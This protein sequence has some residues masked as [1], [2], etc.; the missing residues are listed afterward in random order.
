PAAPQG[1][2]ATDGSQASGVAITWSAVAGATGYRV[3][4]G[5]S[6]VSL[7]P[8]ASVS[9]LTWFD[10]SAQPGVVYT[11]AVRAITP[12]GDGPQSAADTGFAA[13]VT[14]GVTGVNAS[15]G[16]Q[17]SG[18]RIVWQPLAAA[19][20]YRI[21]RSGGDE[22]LQVGAVGASTTIFTDNSIQPG[23]L[24]TYFVRATVVGGA[25]GPPSQV[26]TGWRAMLAPLGVAASDGASLDGIEVSWS[27][28]QGAIEYRVFRSLGNAAPTPVGTTEGQLQFRDTSALSGLTYSYVVRA[29]GQVEGALSP[30]SIPNEGWR[31]LAAPTGVAASDGTT[32]GGVLV[33]WLPSSG[34]VTYRIS[35]ALETQGAVGPPT[36]IAVGVTGLQFNDST[37]AVGALYRYRVQAVAAN[38][39]RVS[40]LSVFDAGYLLLPSP[41]SVNATDGTSTVQVGVSWAGVPGA[42]GYQVLRRI[43]SAPFELLGSVNGAL[44]WADVTANPGQPYDYAIRSVAATGVSQPS[45]VDT[46]YRQLAAPTGIAASDGTRSDGVMVQWGGSN[47]AQSFE[48]WRSLGSAAP[49]RLA[50]LSASVPREYIDAGAIPGVVYSFTV[51]AVGLIGVSASSAA[52]SGFRQAV[53]PNSVLA[54][55]GTSTQHVAVSWSAV[56]SALGYKVLRSTGGS[57]PEVRATLGATVVTWN[58]SQAASGVVYEYS[59]RTVMPSGESIASGADTGYRG[60]TAPVG[61]QASDGSSSAHVA[62][63]WLSVSGAT[64]YQV[65]RSVGGGTP[66]ILGS[67]PTGQLSFTDSTAMHGQVFN[68]FVAALN[69]AGPSALSASNSGYRQVVPPLDVQATDG[70]LPSGVRISWS[71]SAGATGYRVFRATMNGSVAG[72]VTQIGVTSNALEFVDSSAAFGVVYRYSLRTVGAPNGSVSVESTGDLGSRGL[73]APINFVATDGQFTDRVALSWTASAGAESYQVFRG[74][75][76]SPLV[77]SIVGTSFNDTSAPAGTRFNYSVRAVGPTGSSAPSA[78]DDGFRQL[79]SPT[80]VQA[81]DGLSSDSVSVSWNPVAGAVAYELFRSGASTPITV[82]AATNFVDSPVNGIPAVGLAYSYTVRARGAVGISAPSVADSGYRA[83]PAPTGVVASDG[84]SAL[85]VTVSWNAVP[86]AVVYRVWRATGSAPLAVIATV[87]NPGPYVDSTASIG[88]VHRYAVS[89]VSAAGNGLTSPSDDGCRRLASPSGIAASDG[90]ST[91]HVVINWQA[92]VGAVGYQVFRDGSETPIAEV[93]SGFSVLDTQALPGVQHA[94]AVRAQGAATAMLSAMSSADVGF[95]QMRAPESVSA[96][97]GDLLAGVQVSWSSVVGATAYQVLRSP[98]TNGVLGPAVQRGVVL[99]G[100]PGGLVFL[101]ALAVPGVRYAYGVAAVGTAPGAASLPS[102]FDFGHRNRAGATNVQASENIPAHVL[103]TWTLAAAGTPAVSGYEVRRVVGEETPVV[104]TSALAATVTQYDDTTAVPGT[105]YTYEVR[106]RYTLAGSSPA[107]VVTTLPGSDG[108]MRPVPA[109]SGDGGVAGGGDE[110]GGADDSALTEAGE[111][112]EGALG[113]AS[114]AAG[115]GSTEPGAQQPNGDG[116]WSDAEGDGEDTSV[117]GA[118]MRG[119]ASRIAAA[120]VAASTAGSTEARVHANERLESLEA[121]REMIAFTRVDAS[122]QT[123]Q[124]TERAACAMQRGDM[125]LD[126]EVDGRDFALFMD[127]WRAGDEVLAD[128]DRSGVVNAHDLAQMLAAVGGK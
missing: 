72:T 124:W 30:V 63:T 91:A 71:A 66:V 13:L 103:V 12:A 80:G 59:L 77:E 55:D 100:Q 32:A 14:G 95:R 125:N 84:T 93:T 58:D 82:T 54:S 49:V 104:L 117:C 87:A 106:A 15:D 119:L 24:A 46:G 61:V 110:G 97:D 108:G 26:D 52:D 45:P 17:T 39:L 60:L 89:A 20:G 92:V 68:Y 48:V 73:S 69:T 101:D 56:T 75:S 50:T 9:Q 86:A 25:L 10:G 8:V 31:A 112:V 23:T 47:G 102:A 64:S 85:T 123:V 88:V 109:G 57:I 27:A 120:G 128:L 33:S 44:Q 4:R 1:L 122:G 67:T 70:T 37:A 78:S 42:T 111:R 38:P 121:L 3:L 6:A 81:S 35:R 22:P 118:V 113:G 40:E 65:L 127:A 53:P 99:D 11:Y 34:A 90:S 16:T 126:G 98:I 41:A 83:M 76:V 19:T 43:G 51:K 29:V 7:S 21:F 79:L 74:D 116:S 115:S 114:T 5:T 96:S 28:A 2:Q 107:V 62:V 18:V 36:Q 94:Y 105:Q